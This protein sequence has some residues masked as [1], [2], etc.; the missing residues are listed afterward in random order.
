MDL[1]LEMY[2]KAILDSTLLKTQSNLC[3]V[4][5][6]L[7]ERAYRI[8]QDTCI[9]HCMTNMSSDYINVKYAFEEHKVTDRIQLWE[10]EEGEVLYCM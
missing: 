2:P 5:H 8:C 10:A 7:F 3:D 1:V 4:T 6:S 9:T